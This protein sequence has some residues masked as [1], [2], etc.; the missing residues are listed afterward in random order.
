MN[1]PVLPFGGKK[2]A[3]TG[4]PYGGKAGYFGMAAGA[5]L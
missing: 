4:L 3:L 5:V 1:F 2:W